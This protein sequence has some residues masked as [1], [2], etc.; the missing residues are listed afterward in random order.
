M[1]P[2]HLPPLAVP[3]L[4]QLAE[5]SPHSDR[6]YVRCPRSGHGLQG[7]A[8]RDRGVR[9]APAP[10]VPMLDE[11]PV[12]TAL[13]TREVVADGPSLARGNNRN[14]VEAVVQDR[15]RINASDGPP[16]AGPRRLAAFGL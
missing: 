3:V 6:P 11:G 10:A 5:V 12:R 4:D 2:H 15:M 16:G 7:R 1:R 9:E 14:G 8:G 13:A